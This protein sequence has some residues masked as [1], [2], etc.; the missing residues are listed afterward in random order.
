MRSRRGQAAQS[1]VRHRIESRIWTSPKGR[2]AESHCLVTLDVK[3][4]SSG[5]GRGIEFWFC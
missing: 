1:P 2:E 5:L 3:C 4:A